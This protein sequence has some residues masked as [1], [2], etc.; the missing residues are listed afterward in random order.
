MDSA[1]LPS[2]YYYFLS[3]N[4]EKRAFPEQF[5][6]DFNLTTVLLMLFCCCF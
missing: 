3:D 6:N 5:L 2:E 4:T 1:A